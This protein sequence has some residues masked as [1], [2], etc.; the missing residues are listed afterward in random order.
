MTLAEIKQINQKIYELNTEISREKKV[1][2]IASLIF[3]L[4]NKDFQNPNKLSSL[5]NFSPSAENP[6]DQLLKISKQEIDKLNLIKETGDAIKKALD[7]IAGENTK[8]S[9]DRENLK[10][11]ISNFISNVYPAISQHPEDL[12]LER[13]YME[14][15]KKASK[16][17]DGIVLTPLFAAELMV[18]FASIDYKKDVVADLCSGTGLFSLLSYSKMLGK[19]KADFDK[20]EISREVYNKYNKQVLCSIIANDNDSKML[21]L[22]LANFLLNSLNH[23]LIFYRNVLDL[24]RSDFKVNDENDKEKSIQPTKAILNPPYEDKYKPV[25]IVEKNISLVQGQNGA[26]VVVIIPPQKFGQKK[27]VFSR[28]LNMARLDSVI[29]MQDDLFTDSGKS[30]PASIFIFDCSREH[31]KT[32]KIKYYNF[33]DT[34][35]IYLKDSGLVDKNHTFESK[36]KE[37][38]S[39]M[40]NPANIANISEFKRVWNNFYEV[41]KE[42]EVETQIDP[43]KIASSKE[44]ADI[45]L[46]NITI[47]KMLKEKQSLIESVGNNFKDLDGS[48]EKYIVG[49]LSED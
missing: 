46:E 39:K 9:Q 25:E 42:L 7:I 15:D 16:G 1:I 26:R 37:L 32:D 36:K 33:T 43:S 44:E 22:C 24:V 38:L 23:N 34:G 49:I 14:I 6:I 21:T 28:I 3:A 35:F 17:D 30:Q 27:D 10:A 12:F 40:D 45:T 18:D 29:K 31:R 48:F 47:K 5:I 4:Q 41:N 2:F 20:G 8:L 13:L 19:M 11:F